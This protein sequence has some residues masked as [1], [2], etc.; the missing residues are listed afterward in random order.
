[1]NKAEKLNA[2]KE[3]VNNWRLNNGVGPNVTPS[4]EVVPFKWMH[5]F[6]HKVQSEDLK[7][8]SI[9]PAALRALQ[10]GTQK[11]LS[12]KEIRDL[13]RPFTKPDQFG[14]PTGSFKGA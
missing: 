9:E 8:A 10:A 14:H 12:S 2:T 13:L 1:M 7:I 3:W 5:P 6:L 4:K 11:G